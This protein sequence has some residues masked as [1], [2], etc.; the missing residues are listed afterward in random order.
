MEALWQCLFA[1]LCIINAINARSA[2]YVDFQPQQIHIAF[3][4]IDFST[5]VSFL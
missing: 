3:G 5:F 2:E 4:G 1:V